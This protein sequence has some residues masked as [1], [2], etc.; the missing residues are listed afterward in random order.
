VRILLGRT[1]T[2]T[3][4]GRRK[5]RPINLTG[6]S[7]RY[8][9]GDAEAPGQLDKWIAGQD[10][11]VDAAAPYPILASSPADGTGDDSIRQAELRTR[12]LIAAVR[13]HDTRLVYI[14][15]CVTLAR[16]PTT[17]E[18]FQT[19]L[20]RIAHPYFYVKELIE[21]NLLDACRRGLRAVILD[22]AYCLGP[23][24]VRAPQ[25]CTIPLL[26]KREIPSSIDQQL[27]VIDVR[28]VAAAMLGTLEAE[29][30]GQP[31]LLSAYRISAHHLYSFICEIAGVSPP[32]YSFPAEAV[33]L[34]AYGLEVILGTLG[35]ETPLSSGAIMISTMFN[36]LEPGKELKNLGIAPR[37][38]SQTITDSIKWY[39]Q[40]GY[41]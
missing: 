40:I 30:Y 6:L 34:G 1:H 5:K 28:D 19:K 18:Q 9:V 2:V 25:Y 17:A 7:I 22:P 16:P 10:L 12:R 24:D 37:P 21:N 14:G 26:L 39:R 33:L 32:R 31:I 23:W 11:V 35:I 4:C 36:Y 29:R 13:K 20:M 8:I 3:A 15:S 38:L 41:C 27:H